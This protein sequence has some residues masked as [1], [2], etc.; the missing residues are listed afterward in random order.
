MFDGMSSF[1]QGKICLAL[2]CLKQYGIPL[3]ENE[4]TP[5][6]IGDD[7]GIY[8]FIPQIAQTFNVSV[9]LAT[10]IF[11]IGLLFISSIAGATGIFRLFK[12]NVV[13]ICGLIMLLAFIR[14][15][16]YV[17]DV[18]QAPAIIAIGL[19]PL[20]LYAFSRGGMRIQIATLVWG[21]L[22]CSLCNQ[23]RSHSGT[24]GIIFLITCVVIRCCKEQKVFQNILLRTAILLICSVPVWGLMEYQLKQ[25]N[26]F[27][28]QHGVNAHAL[29]NRHFLWHNMYMGLGWLP[30]QHGIVWLDNC[31]ENKVLSMTPDVKSGSIRYESELRRYYFE[32]VKKDPVFVIKTYLSKIV[33]LLN[34]H[35]PIVI[36]PLLIL[37]FSPRR[38]EHW[39]YLAMFLPMLQGFAMGIISMPK[40]Y[41]YIM[42]GATTA[43]IFCFLVFADYMS[44]GIENP[45]TYPGM[46]KMWRRARFSRKKKF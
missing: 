43:L 25:R 4:K 19:I 17:T 3:L 14:R 27:L 10:Q 35:W 7:P 6:M 12:S 41:P 2:E 39:F 16:F 18:Y 31:P 28:I 46:V 26:D 22:L 40:E 15:G 38:Y 34:L 32:I 23:V 42:G 45:D 30:N 36:L 21:G 8:Y 13:R 29:A 24:M 9:P 37:L 44:R 11:F 1:R 33:Y 20:G 5:A